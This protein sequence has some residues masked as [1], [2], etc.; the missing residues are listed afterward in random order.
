MR[1]S[2]AG[3][4]SRTIHRRGGLETF[5]APRT[6]W[7]AT[8]P[9]RCR[10]SPW[11]DQ[12][13]EMRPDRR[14]EANETISF[15]QRAGKEEEAG[16]IPAPSRPRNQIPGGPWPAEDKRGPSVAR[17]G[18]KAREEHFYALIAPRASSR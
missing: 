15:C 7:S 8:P 14:Q 9:P 13:D 17:G 10:A 12:R 16:T 4:A 1:E 6:I 18:T 2:N 3:A 11:R 5:N